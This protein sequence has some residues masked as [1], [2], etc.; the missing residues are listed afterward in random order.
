MTATAPGDT[1]I[2]GFFNCSQYCT[3]SKLSGVDKSIDNYDMILYCAYRTANPAV[4]S[5]HYTHL[6][7]KDCTMSKFTDIFESVPSEP[8]GLNVYVWRVPNIT[9]F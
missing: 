3:I 1:I 8:T 5:S 2:G 9:H 7:K 4:C 6:P